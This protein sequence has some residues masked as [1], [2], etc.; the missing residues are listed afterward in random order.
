MKTKTLK[1]YSLP[2]TN[3]KQVFLVVSMTDTVDY[4]PGQILGKPEVETLCNANGWKVSIE[5]AKR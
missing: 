2:I 4:L 5:A 3:G 1:L